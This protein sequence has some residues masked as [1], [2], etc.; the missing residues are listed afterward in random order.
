LK[1]TSELPALLASL[2]ELLN[3]AGII[4][5]IA[6]PATG[7]LRPA[8]AHG[9]PANALTHIRAISTDAD[10]ATASAFRHGTVQVVEADQSGAG[11]IAVPLVTPDGCVGVMA[12]EVRG[13]G[14][15]HAGT[16]AIAAIVAAQMA[17]LVAP[18]PVDGQ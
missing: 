6:E 9:Y 13:G 3:A 10:N 15:R 18:Q 14:E 16:Q 17:T 2:A 5:W 4:V 1:E 8:A 7:E 11:A 12:A